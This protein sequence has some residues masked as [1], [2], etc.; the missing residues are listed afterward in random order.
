MTTGRSDNQD[1]VE[2]PSLRATLLVIVLAFGVTLAAR[3]GM[4]AKGQDKGTPKQTATEKR[5]AEVFGQL[6]K[7]WQTFYSGKYEDAAKQAEALSKLEPR[8]RWVM[9]EAGWLQSRCLW[10][11]DNQQSRT[12]AQQIWK[13]IER[14]D[15]SNATKTRLVIAKALA[16]EAEAQAAGAKPDAAALKLKAAIDTLEPL[17]KAG[18]WNVQEVEAALVLSNLYSNRTVARFDDAKKTLDYIV[19]YLGAEKNLIG[20]ELPPG[21]E[22][23]HIAAAKAALAH[24]KYDKNLGMAEFEAAETLRRAEKFAAA[25]KAYLQIIKDFPESDYAPRSE[26]HIGDCLI[27]LGQ[28]ARAIEHW[29]KFITPLPAGPWRAQAYLRVVDYSLEDA[30]DIGEAGKYVELAKSSLPTALAD[31]K[32]NPSWSAASF[33]IQQRIGLVSFVSGKNE[34]AVEAWSAAAKLTDKKT[35]QE[36]LDALIAAAKSGKGVI[37]DDVKGSD[38]GEMKAAGAA[39]SPKNRASLVLSMGII[40]LVAGRLDN[41]EAMFDRVLGTP[42]APAKPGAPGH[43][44]RPAMAGAT[45]AQL[46]FATFGKGATSQARSGK[47]E[48]AK[49]FF[50]ASIKAFGD[51]SWHD[52]SVFRVASITQDEGNSKFGKVPEPA[53]KPGQPAKPLTPAEKEAA[54]KAEKERLAAL[55]KAKGEALAYWKELINRYPSSPRCEQAYYQ[56]GVLLCEIAEASPPAQS[57][58]LWKE[59]A[60]MLSRFCESYPNSPMAGDAYVRQVDIGLQGIFDIDLSRQLAAS[61]V[62]WAK[63]QPEFPSDEPPPISDAWRALA[64]RT[65]PIEIRPAVYEIYLRAGLIAYLD[66]RYDAAQKFFESA[67]P[68][69]PP[70]DFVVVEG[71]IPTGIESITTAAREKRALTPPEVLDG[72]AK[73]RLI[74]QLGDIYLVAGSYEKSLELATMIT[75]DLKKSASV[76]QCSW[77]HRG[78]AMALS[79]LRLKLDAKPEFVAAQETS[80]AAPWA[81][82]C[83]FLAG[84]I[85]HNHAKKPQEAIGIFEDVVRQYPTSEFAAKAAY[86]VGVIHEWNGQWPQAKTAYQRVIRDYPESRWASAAMGFHMK[87]VDAALAAANTNKPKEK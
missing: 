83:L 70:R 15:T 62:D 35:V 72:D 3:P 48:E 4:T 12:K 27:G 26:L 58:K 8:F 22:K 51:G 67:K 84:T 13:Q 31:E 87:K 17:L 28:N 10:A 6:G 42:A 68:M 23:P 65:S 63:A 71:R 81:S 39:V 32:A 44:A 1:R 7:C 9:A 47:P 77:A 46:A 66:Q 5:D 21:L 20:M 79:S 34:Q 43:P 53:A 37:P 80:P 85:V 45:Q 86:F 40:H 30:L 55:L 59:A 76:L 82:E 16:M 52:E 54:A 41:A 33:D 36:S 56:A 74:L 78:R 61:A 75:N 64:K 19:S 60:S 69:T 38:T 24:L 29:K 50:L 49:D 73:V 2:R 57:E 18:R 14:V 11:A 25:Q